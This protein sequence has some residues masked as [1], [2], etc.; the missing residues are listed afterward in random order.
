MRQFQRMAVL[1]RLR[2]NILLAANVTHQRHHHLFADG[3][4]GRVRNLRKKLFEVIEK[5]LR[6]I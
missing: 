6:F 3:V 2:Q 5:R 4:N 1:R